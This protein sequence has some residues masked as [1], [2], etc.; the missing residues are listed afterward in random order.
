MTASFGV[1]RIVKGSSKAPIVKIDLG[2]K[3]GEELAASWI[4]NKQCKYC[5]FGF[6]LRNKLTSP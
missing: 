3:D 5:H 4:H 2:S 6:A 1:D